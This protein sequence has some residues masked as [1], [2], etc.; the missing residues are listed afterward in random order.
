MIAS[1][2]YTIENAKSGSQVLNNT[3]LSINFG[4]AGNWIY[5]SLNEKGSESYICLLSLYHAFFVFWCNEEKRRLKEFMPAVEVVNDTMKAVEYMM[6]DWS[7]FN[8]T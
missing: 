4:Y 3:Y 8:G 5:L 2:G 6:P 7:S 1:E